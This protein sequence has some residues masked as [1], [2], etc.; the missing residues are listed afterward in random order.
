MS[1]GDINKETNSNNPS[2][3]S[4]FEKVH[5]KSL[6][7]DD[8]FEDFPIDTWPAEESLRDATN[9]QTSLWEEDWDDVEVDD[10][11]TKE[12]KAELAKYKQQNQ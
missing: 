4:D 3:I 1:S 8:E 9:A 7:E 6:E 10:D 2:T 11:F 5:K 12:L